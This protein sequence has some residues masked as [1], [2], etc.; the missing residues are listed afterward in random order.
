MFN[1]AMIASKS[2][3]FLS[4]V[5][6][7]TQGQGPDVGT[8]VEYGSALGNSN[9][10]G[11]ITLVS[12]TTSPMVLNRLGY[13]IPDPAPSTSG[14]TMR[15]RGSITSS[16]PT[17][18][19]GSFIEFLVDKQNQPDQ[20]VL[21]NAPGDYNFN[22]IFNNSDDAAFE[23]LLRDIGGLNDGATIQVNSLTFTKLA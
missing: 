23:F 18:G 5:Y 6:E 1:N 19:A 21:I 13:S 22:F 17:A 4:V 3:S 15:V 16:G 2:L 9:G 12:A 14:G 11:L 7:F 8:F 10:D 20:V